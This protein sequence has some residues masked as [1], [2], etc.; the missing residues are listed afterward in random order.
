MQLLL[1]LLLTSI[2]RRCS[3]PSSQLFIIYVTMTSFI[4][5]PLSINANAAAI[6]KVTFV[7]V[8]AFSMMIVFMT[9]ASSDMMTS[10]KVSESVSSADTVVCTR[11]APSFGSDLYIL[12]AK[13]AIT[14]V[15]DVM[16][17]STRIMFFMTAL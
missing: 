2:K 14:A 16:I 4:H 13:N 5:W 11:S 9:R 7:I 3:D 15:I 17:S 6:A 12:Y 1:G 10:Y 8:A